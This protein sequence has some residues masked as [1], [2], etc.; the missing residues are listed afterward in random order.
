MPHTESIL[1]A[2][3]LTSGPRH[4]FFGYY[5][6]CPWDAS[7]RYVLAMESEFI[8]RP[9]R[10]R[11][12]VTLGV[13]DLQDG[14]RWLPFAQTPAWHWQLG[15]MLQWLPARGPERLVIYNSRQGDRY[16]SV[17]RDLEAGEVRRL[18]RPVYPVS[19]DGRTALSI[20]MSRLNDFRPGYGYVGL[21]DEWEDDPAPLGDGIYR[22]DLRTGECSL[23]ISVAQ[24]AETTPRAGMKGAGHYFNHLQFNTDDS[25]FLFLHR[26]RRDGRRVTRM[27]TAAPDG[28]DLFCV[29]DDELVSHFDWR[30]ETHILA[31]ARWRDEGDHYFLFTDRSNRAEQVGPEVLTEDGHCSYSPDRRWI[32]TDTYPNADGDRLLILY[33]P[34]D[35]LRVDIGRFHSPP[36]LKGP[37]RCDL[38]PRWNRAGTQVCIDSAHEATRQM[39]VVD[40]GGVVKS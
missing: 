22:M 39:Y 36:E 18:P 28:S 35:D 29:A 15:A 20:N 19:R 24:I 5:D 9:P 32:L 8:D 1:P 37:I 38:H 2:V 34:E 40:V 13:V 30:D 21:R 14:G 25:R 11:D 31:W 26:W 12:T 16:I 7:G 4:H 10:G 23:I 6:K 17:I 33:R 3:P 27:F